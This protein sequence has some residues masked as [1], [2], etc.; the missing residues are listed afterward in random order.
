MA[1][2]PQP[3]ARTCW[4]HA[5]GDCNKLSREHVVSR[6]IFASWCSCPTHVEGICRM[7]SGLRPESALTAKILCQKHNSALSPLDAEAGKLSALLLHSAAGQHIGRPELSGSLIERW[8]FK[9]LINGLA[10][11]WSDRRKWL[12]SEQIV[13]FIFGTESLPRGCGLYSIDGS[14]EDL[15]NP[16]DA[17]VAP[18]WM[19]T[20]P[21]TKKL[22]GG[23]VRINGL[24]FF[25]AFHDQ[26]VPRIVGKP[27]DPPRVFEN[28]SIRFV[29]QP[30][31]ISVGEK[32]GTKDGIILRWGN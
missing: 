12:P 11:G 29:Y 19:G 32:G 5:L 31:W 16:Q 20:D 7:P 13:R 6:S 24:R 28:E 27:E 25:A 14:S 15:P 17:A 26:I 22:V 9:T 8:V 18:L 3:P 2:A 10:A 30:A 21:I 4:A 23:Q 1:T